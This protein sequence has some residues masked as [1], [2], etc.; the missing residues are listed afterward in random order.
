MTGKLGA[1]QTRRGRC[2]R[3]G[4]ALAPMDAR[5]AWA[6]RSS[7]ALAL[8][9]DCHAA[10]LLT[11][12]AK[13]S[14]SAVGGGRTAHPTEGVMLDGLLDHE[15]TRRRD[16]IF[17]KTEAARSLGISESYV[18]KLIRQGKARR[19]VVTFGGRRLFSADDVRA[20]AAA[21]GRADPLAAKEVA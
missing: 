18:D 16:P 6:Q 14:C 9:P 4:A 7:P 8:C 11:P 13:V 15:A 10:L 1:R 12:A 17:T 3:C 19:T 5:S 21:I 2:R 20:M